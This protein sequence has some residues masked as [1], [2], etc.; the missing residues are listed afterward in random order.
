MGELMINPFIIFAG[1]L[2]L[3][4]GFISYRKNKDMRKAILAAFITLLV[5]YILA[6]V[7]DLFIE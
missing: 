4:S 7:I 5:I 1:I 6:F 3:V 2:V